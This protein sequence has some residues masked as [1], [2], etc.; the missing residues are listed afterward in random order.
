MLKFSP[1]R[2]IQLLCLVLLSWSCAAEAISLGSAKLL[3]KP[4][5]PLRV[6]I[7]ILVTAE[8]Q[9]TLSS[10]ETTIPTKA[11]YDRLGI[12]SK[13]LDFNARSTVYRNKQ[14]QLT[15][16]VETVYP[17]PSSD[18]PF[19]NL[20]VNLSWPS[21]NLTK[22]FTLLMGDGQ[23]ILVKPGQTLSE[24][25]AQMAPQFDG[26]SLDQAMMALFKANP[27][28]FASGSINH[29]EA[30]VEL[31]SPNQALL[32]SISPAEANKFV[33]EFYAQ[34]R[35]EHGSKGAPSKNGADIAV[36]DRL[37]IGSSSEGNAEE[38]RYT[39]DLVAQ[40]VILEQTKKQVA[41]LEKNIVDLQKLLDKPN[42][43]SKDNSAAN[44]NFGLGAFA[45]GILALALIAFA[46]LLL[47]LLAKNSRRAL[48]GDF[49]K[50]APHPHPTL[51]KDHSAS[52]STMPQRAKALFAGIDLDLSPSKP[53]DNGTQKPP[54]ESD[55]L[56]DTLRVKLNLACAYITIEDF[57]AAKKSLEEILGVSGP[58]DPAI[59]IEAQALLSELA[60]RNG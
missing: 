33:A 51:I 16:L 43:Q 20:L 57:S 54:Q 48:V 17:I 13:V 25:A 35:A 47:W 24:I 14:E 55:P 40:E 22:T 32:H 28:A 36:K 27:D 9:A 7:P 10:L 41:Q 26:V 21:G 5:E 6:E 59:S 4:N 58:I 50:P 49:T 31:A 52:H 23:R 12:S 60:H 11:T 39:E 8:E 2:F 30:G 15:V 44:N 53:S 46:G 42:I 56:A 38:R 29:L 34:W 18:D 19:I 1:P 3:S 37:K 45:P